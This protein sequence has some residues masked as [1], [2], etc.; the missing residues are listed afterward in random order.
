M[1]LPWPWWWYH[2]LLCA[3]V[4]THQ[5]VH[6]KH[7]D[8]V[9]RLYFNKAVQ[10][11][12]WTIWLTTQMVEDVAF[13]GGPKNAKSNIGQSGPIE[14]LVLLCLKRLNFPVGTERSA[15][16]CIVL[17]GS[18]L[19]RFEVVVDWLRIGQFRRAEVQEKSKVREEVRGSQETMRITADG[20]RAAGEAACLS[21][22]PVLTVTCQGPREG[23]SLLYFYFKA[24]S[25]L[26]LDGSFPGI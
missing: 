21:L 25:A 26:S 10:K 14:N 20:G 12:P 13:T 23:W 16:V 5:V 2:S 22:T 4:Q 3:H 24:S 17:L 9:Y 18:G 6:V 15:Q 8:C 7:A 1:L 11:T 19:V